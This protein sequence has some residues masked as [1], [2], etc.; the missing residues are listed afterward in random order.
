ML[1][2]DMGGCKTYG[3]R[4]TYQRTRPPEKFWTPLQKS[5]W[6][7]SVVDF[8]TGKTEQRHPRGVENVPYEGVPKP[9][10]GRGVIREVFLPPLFSTP[11]GVL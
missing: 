11:H 5:F 7:A 9:L 8:C 10:F 4:Q 6:S 3:G 2:H 1:G